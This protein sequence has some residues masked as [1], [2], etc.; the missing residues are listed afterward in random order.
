MTV[1]AL[2]RRLLSAAV[3]TATVLSPL[4]LMPEAAT[5]VIAPADAVAPVTGSGPIWTPVEGALRSVPAMQD[6][7]RRQ[8]NPTDF[9]AFT[10]DL[11]RLSERLDAA[12]DE[13]AGGSAPLIVAIPA[14]TGELVRF[15]VKE[16]SVMEAGLAAARPDIKT[17]AGR[18]VSGPPASIRLDTTPLGFHAS[19]RDAASTWYVDPAYNGPDQGRD[20]LYVSYDVKSQPAPEQKLIEPEPIPTGD[21]ART[22]KR[23]TSDQRIFEGAGNKVIART[24]RIAFAT[25]PTYSKYFAPNA[26]TAAEYN[27][28]V[29]AAKATLMNRVNHIYGDDLSLRM[30]LVDETDKTN[31]NT[32]AVAY[33]AGGPCGATACYVATDVANGCSSTLLTRNKNVLGQVIG[34]AN[35]EVGHIGLGL[36]GGGLASLGVVGL[37]NKA[38]GCTGLPAPTGDSFAVD[39]VAHEIGHTFAGNHTFDGVTGSCSATN[40]NA[41][42]SV[43]P[44]S[45]SSVMAYAG[46]CQ[47]D[48]LQPH[49]DPY[50]SQRSQTEI[51]T[52][53]TASKASPNEIQ[54]VS[55]VGFDASDSFTLTFPGLGTTVPITN[56][57][58]YSAAGIKAAVETVTGSTV[59]VGAYFGSAAFD[60]AG[61]QMTYSGAKAATNVV[62][63]VVNVAAGTFSAAFND[64]V[65]GG[66][67]TNGGLSSVISENRVPVVSAPPARTIPMRTPFE[68]TGTATDPDGDSMIYLW[69]QNDRGEIGLGSSLLNA[70]RTQGPLFRVF[71]SYA[72]VTP[73]GTLQYES[74]G[75]NI[76]TDSLTRTFPDI[77]QIVAGSTNAATGACPSPSSPPGTGGLP[78]GPALECYSELL[79]SASYIG[80]DYD[81]ALNFRFTARDLGGPD[82]GYDGGTQSADTKLTVDPTAGPFLVNSQATATSVAGSSSGTITW[83]VAGTGTMATDV[84]ILLSTDGGLTYPITLLAG[85][86]NDGSQAITWPNVA[87]TKARVKVAAVDNYF[88]DINDA[89]IT[90]NAQPGLTLSGNTPG[91]FPTQYSDTPAPTPTITA[92]S[93]TVNGSAITATPT[94][95]PAGLALT[96]QSASADGVRPGTATFTVTGADTAAPGTFPV[97]VTV[98][99]GAAPNKVATFTVEVSKE[100]ATA[101]YTG[102]DSATATKGGTDAVDVELKADIAQADDGS[103]GDLTTATATFTDTVS[104]ETLCTSPVTAAGKAACTFGADLTGTSD[105]TYQVKVTVGGSNYTGTTES[106]SPL[107]VSYDPGLVVS[108]PSSTTPSVQYSDALSPAVTVDVSAHTVAS[109]HFTASST[110]LP[111]GL[112]VTRIAASPA[113]TKPG[114]G[115]YKITGAVTGAPGSYP[116][117]LTFNDGVHAAV[118]R[119]LTVLVTREDATATYTGPDSATA[120][121]GGTDAVDVDLKAD[122]AQAADGS[123]G[124]LTTATATFTDTV[125]SE[126]LCTSPVT[127]AG[128]AA[129]T[130]GAD[131]T[132]TDDRTYQV[133]VTVGG[134][135]FTGATTA[136]SPLVVTFD[137]DPGLVVSEP[138][139]SA[140]SVQYSDALDPA[141]TLDVSAQ[142]V[143]SEDFTAAATGLPTGLALTRTSASPAGTKPGTATYTVAGSVTG[144]P[145]SYPVTIT[146]GDGT[147][148]DVDRTLTVLVTREDATATYTGPTQV[149]AGSEATEKTFAMTAEVVAAADGTTG[150]ITTARVDFV[151]TAT[152]QMLCAGAAVV[153][154]TAGTGTATCDVTA[155]LPADD[156]RTYDVRL[157]VGERYTGSS[158][159]DTPVTV[160]QDTTTGDTT[161]P[162]T[163]ITSGPRIN[164]FVLDR[165]VRFGYASEPDATYTCS[166]GPRSGACP[167]DGSVAVRSLRPG[168]YDF[169]VAATDQ[170]GNTD[171]SPATR[172][173]HVPVNDRAFT[174]KGSSWTRKRSSAS[175]RGSYSQARSKNAKLTYRITDATSLALIYGGAKRA[176]SVDVYLGKTLLRRINTRTKNATTN[177]LA[178]IARF[179]EPQSGTVRIITRNGRRVRVE[180]LGVRQ[181]VSPKTT[182][183]SS[184]TTGRPSLRGDLG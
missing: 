77:R 140:P 135:N 108:E 89:D 90:I 153:Q 163:S 180:G 16:S 48:N 37:A 44:G 179:S 51:G 133:K 148:A 107:V 176:G 25:D 127:A 49:T 174:V 125:S 70:A 53:M 101:A 6:G 149:T 62:N 40:R 141:V 139:D 87:T 164:S 151:D 171:D 162:E 132:G 93:A 97:S 157:V 114:T 35:F 95:L 75:E 91:T 57:S 118:Q 82:G 13:T 119:T 46:I 152:G 33:E 147:H 166:V 154:D 172:R 143:A 27:L 26:T 83:A 122:I 113:G 65:Q 85:T 14:P 79:P 175:Y 145:G 170:A 63:P 105:R 78:D 76:A 144:A 165:V 30:V 169:A 124:D 29:T 129:C 45:G 60:T 9:A 103:L 81:N 69:E 52:H 24:Y 54:S 71:G 156:G 123:L 31:F 12:P 73:A 59:T 131:L 99:D 92:T 86:P 94:G 55:L 116:V 10:L 117:T 17:Y 173:F 181:V 110:G 102:P 80:Y 183:R 100:D 142:T 72:P 96:R 159:S 74:P 47:T 18:T 42:N 41:P 56:G 104:S 43:E 155:S 130:F 115:T 19:V 88:F 64:I 150:D 15:A 184:T 28:L 61:F 136:D 137:A 5:A 160:T 1:S 2:S 121:Q 167:A 21:G 4:A 98:A 3:A 128:K 34:A 36:N 50:F 32:T 126:T 23:S 106:D 84:A 146:I 38:Q 158:T 177:K 68:L 66:A 134:P 58:N 39:Y 11:P 112:T 8:V 7:L 20:A 67:P 161:P 168:S 120:T 22:L 111:A 109:E 182:T 178:A 138:S